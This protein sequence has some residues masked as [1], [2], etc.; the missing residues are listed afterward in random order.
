MRKDLQTEDRMHDPVYQ[1]EVRVKL[2]AT[3]TADDVRQ[4]FDAEFG[5]LG[6]KRLGRILTRRDP[7]TGSKLG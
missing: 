6:W 2:E 7:E 4:V 1:E 3:K 5:D